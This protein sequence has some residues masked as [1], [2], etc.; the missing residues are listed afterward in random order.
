MLSV[1]VVKVYVNHGDM[2][3]K[4]FADS[5]GVP[6]AYVFQADRSG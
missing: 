1:C 5:E 2:N 4:N 6:D 3:I